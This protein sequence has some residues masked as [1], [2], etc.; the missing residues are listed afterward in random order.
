MRISRIEL[1]N[2]LIAPSISLDDNVI[3][4]E[5]PSHKE[6]K[7]AMESIP[8]DNSPRPDGFSLSFHMSCWDIVGEDVWEVAADFFINAPG[9]FGDF[10]P[11]SLCLVIY[12]CFAKVIVNRLKPL[13]PKFIS[14][15]QGAF[16]RGR[17]IFNNI[18]LVQE[19]L[20]NFN[21]KIQGENA[22]LK[23]DTMKAYDRLE[24]NFLMAVI[25]A[26]GFSTRFCQLIQNCIDAPSFSVMMHGTYR[27]F[28]NLPGESIKEISS[29]HTY[30][31]LLR[32]LLHAC[33]D[34]KASIKALV[35]ILGIY[36]NMSGQKVNHRKSVIFFSKHI[37]LS[38]KNKSLRLSNFTQGSFPITYLGAPISPGRLCIRHFEA[39]I[40]KGEADGKAK[41]T[42]GEFW[43]NNQASIRRRSKHSRLS[44]STSG[45]KNKT[46]LENV[47]LCF[48]TTTFPKSKTFSSYNEIQIS[49]LNSPFWKSIA[50]LIP[51]VIENSVWHIKSGDVNLWQDNWFGLTPLSNLVEVVEPELRLNVVVTSR[52]WNE[53]VLSYLIWNDLAKAA[54]EYVPKVR[55]GVDKVVWK[56]SP[57]GMFSTRSTWEL[58][59]A[60][61]EGVDW[62]K[63]AIWTA[64]CQKKMEG[65]TINY[66]QIW[67]S[68]K[69][70]MGE[71]C[72][73]V[74]KVS[75]LSLS[76]CI[77][78]RVLGIQKRKP[79]NKIS[80]FVRWIPPL[81]TWVKLNID[82]CCIGNPG[83][84]GG[85]R[86]IREENGELIYAFYTFYGHSN[87]TWAELKAFLEGI[88]ICVE[89]NFLNIVIES[90]P[91]VVVN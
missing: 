85:G 18:A 60:K 3:L 14:K 49:A 24:W 67:A 43:K 22:M 4:C 47:F 79:H 82:G 59:R 35:E 89:R 61:Q 26:F 30:L 23:V 46:C 58:I 73:N 71:L 25:K 68:A 12:K 64:R 20:R 81:P 10:R 74:A 91:Q 7:S 13:L 75:R 15:E 72:A 44:K 65:T 2:S 8:Q 37:Y 76:N 52:G 11:I 39:L 55:Q 86:V 70:W 34:S 53:D 17:S 63:W 32:G 77:A 90:D 84:C 83:N 54:I 66:D 19:L 27:G 31:L 45:P 1:L 57:D 56:P 42:L 62:D 29:L 28:L 33:Y 16:I 5:A 87:N 6:V 38:R 78:L 36:E 69:Q 40:M 80:K 9:G 48:S 88:H 21:R 41:R 51:I 50:S